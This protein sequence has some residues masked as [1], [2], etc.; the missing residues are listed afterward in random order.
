MNIR[1]EGERMCARDMYFFYTITQSKSHATFHCVSKCSFFL[2]FRE[3]FASIMSILLVGYVKFK[4]SRTQSDYF[5]QL[6]NWFN[7]ILMPFDFIIGVSVV[8]VCSS[9]VI[10]INAYRSNTEK[11]TRFT[12]KSASISSLEVN[13]Q[14]KRNCMVRIQLLQLYRHYQ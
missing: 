1:E 3:F 14:I 11:K 4:C 9:Q 12:L 5:V 7:V 2:S 10:F 6:W 8:C 13:K